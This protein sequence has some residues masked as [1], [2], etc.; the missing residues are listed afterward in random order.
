[1]IVPHGGHGHLAQSVL[2][3]EMPGAIQ[4]RLVHI[5][6]KPPQLDR[7]SVHEEHVLRRLGQIPEAPADVHADAP[8]V[9]LHGAAAPVPVL[10]E[11]PHAPAPVQQRGVAGLGLG[12]GLADARMPRHAVEVLLAV[13]VELSRFVEGR[14]DDHRVVG[15]VMGQRHVHVRIR[16]DEGDADALP[17]VIHAGAEILAR[18]DHRMGRIGR[19]AHPL[20]RP[21]KQAGE[22]VLLAGSGIHQRGRRVAR[23]GHVADGHLQHPRAQLDLEKV[24]FLQR[25]GAGADPLPIVIKDHPA[26]PAGLGQVPPLVQQRRGAGDFMLGHAFSSFAALVRWRYIFAAKYR[27]TNVTSTSTAATE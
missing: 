26:R 21:C 20:H 4:R 5:G 8:P 12:L 9:L 15:G 25:E 7:P 18:T 16:G 23:V 10:G 14:G 13:E 3:P 27:G 19:H 2:V 11:G 6:D 22:A 1:M 24:P 17:A